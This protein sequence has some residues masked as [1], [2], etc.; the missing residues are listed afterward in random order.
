[1]WHTNCG[2]RT[3]EDEENICSDEMRKLK[4]IGFGIFLVCFAC[5]C[6]LQVATAAIRVVAYNNPDDSTE[7]AWFSTVFLAIGDESVNGVAK[8]LDILAV[9]ETDTGSSARLV[10]ILNNLHGVSSYN[11]VTSS[12]V[13]GDRTGIVYDSNTLTLLDSNDLTEIGTHPIMRA[14]FRPVGYTSPDSEFYVYAIHLKSGATASDK[15]QR[16]TVVCLST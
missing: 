1:M 15:D 4:A 2:D 11:V 13:G 5:L 12:S 14:H 9:S 16:A 3:L 10:N 7:D 8:R 6:N